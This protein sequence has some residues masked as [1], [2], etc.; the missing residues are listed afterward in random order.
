MT[1]VA[2]AV[3]DSTT[4]VRRELRHTMRNPGQ[5]AL[6][7]LMPLIMLLL[8]NF[9][10]G[11]ALDTKGIKYINYVVPGIVM[12]GAAYS[13][14]ATALAVNADMTEGIIDRFRT[15][16][17]ARPSVLIGHV[18]GATARSLIGIAIVVLVALAIGFRPSANVVEWL[19]VIGLIALTLFSFAWLATAFGLI[20]KN[21]AGASTMT[22]PLSLL[23]FLGGAFV[24]TDTMPG[25]LRVFAA[26]Q[27]L[28]QIIEALRSLL[29][30][31]PIGD[32]AWLAIAWCLG[33]AVVGFVW[34]TSAFSRRTAVQ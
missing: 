9:A 6:A 11:G 3:A 5:L 20:A 33:I 28:T 16:A 14:Q 12:L 26:N 2:S 24:P 15:M 29:L 21:P 8:L 4:M 10:F 32:H 18:I 25:W 13:A 27:P 34:A 7:M 31:G 17:I 19:G 1:S 22:L 23:P 30:G